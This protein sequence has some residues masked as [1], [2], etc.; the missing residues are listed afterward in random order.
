MGRAGTPTPS[1]SAPRA[2]TPTRVLTA[3]PFPSSAAGRSLISDCKERV[4]VVVRCRPLSEREIA[5]GHKSCVLIDKE[6]N[7]VQIFTFDRAYDESCTQRQLYRD[8]AYSIVHSV[9]CGY[10]GTVLAYGQ[11]ASGK[12]YTMEGCDYCPDL[13]G[14]IPNA[15]EHIFNHIRQSQSSDS[16]LV[17]V[18]Y[19]E[20][21]NEEIHDLL[22]PDTNGR[23]LELKERPE[24]GVYVKNLT[25]LSVNSFADINHLLMVGKRNR[26]VG[27]T[28]MNQDSSRSHSIF[29]VTVETSSLAP[30]GNGKMHV[31]VGKLNLVDLAGSERLAKS[32]ATGERFKEMTKINWSLSALANVISALVDGKATHIPYRDSKLTRLLQDSLGGNTCTVMI[33]NIGPADYNYEESVSTLRYAHRA[34]SIR[35]KPQVNEDPKDAIISEFQSEIQRLKAQIQASQPEIDVMRRLESLEQEKLMVTEQLQQ[36]K[37]KVLEATTNQRMSEQAIACLKADLEGKAQIQLECLK[38]EKERSEEEK[39]KIITQLLKQLREMEHQNQELSRGKEDRALLES[40]L[41]VLEEKLIR[42]TNSGGKNVTEQVKQRSQ[43]LASFGHA[44]EEQKLFNEECQQKM[45]EMEEAQ[46]MAEEKCNTMEEEL[47]LKTRKLRKLMARYQQSKLEIASLKSEIQDTIHEFQQERADLLWSIKSLEQQHQLKNLVIERF[48]PP[49]EVAKI[50]QKMRWDDDSE[51]WIF[52]SS[53]S[54]SRNSTDNVPIQRPA[55]AVGRSRPTCQKA[56]QFLA[57][58]TTNPRYLDENVLKLELESPERVTFDYC[59]PID[60]IR[61]ESQIHQC[62][63]DLDNG[64]AYFSYDS[65]PS[66]LPQY[67]SSPSRP[68]SA[69]VSQHARI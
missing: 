62:L 47:D 20:I 34:K 59:D 2:S 3:S 9:M 38:A 51:V 64:N 65:R 50:M 10:N 40:K 22:S 68:K 69:H 57:Q 44:F 33:A 6:R 63:K 35:N 41:K 19:L 15:F 37:E 58:G 17:R 21:Y 60:R 25:S 8:V 45:I 27:A 43:D 11:T 31:R 23:K 1:Q 16:F 26:A 52:R 46:I 13:W 30:Q 29:T 18:S 4:Q 14:I 55:S 39:E 54:Y 48:I 67:R 66:P 61:A 56:L 24:T 5:A 12:T 49:E 32:G 36:Y 53:H 28:I 42:G 7:T